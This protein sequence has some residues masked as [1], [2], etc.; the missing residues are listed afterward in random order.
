MVSLRDTAPMQELLEL[1]HGLPRQS[2]EPGA[3]LLVD[4]EPV[5]ALYV[6]L[7]GALRIEKGGVPITTVT[8]PGACVGEMSLLLGVP[9]TADVVA[10]EPTVVAVVEDA[11]ADARGTSRAS[12]SRSRG[13]SRRACR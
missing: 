2:L 12:R 7:E 4:G 10:T 13:C 8:E 6:L 5:Q 9:A 1:A 11:R 3:V